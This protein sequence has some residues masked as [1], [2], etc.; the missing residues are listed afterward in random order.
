M[1]MERATCVHGVGQL[2]MERATCAWSVPH[3]C[4]ERAQGVHDHMTVCVH[5]AGHNKLDGFC[6]CVNVYFG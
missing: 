2:C 4:M 1:C 3:V 5:G 6:M